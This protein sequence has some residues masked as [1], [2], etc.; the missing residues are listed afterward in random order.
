MSMPN[1]RFSRWAQLIATANPSVIGRR[2]LPR[3]DG[4][5]KLID[6]L[7]EGLRLVDVHPMS[8]VR[9]DPDDR[10]RHEGRRRCD[11]G[12]RTPNWLSNTSFAAWNSGESNLPVIVAAVIAS[13]A[14]FGNI[15]TSEFASS[16]QRG[17]DSSGPTKVTER[18]PLRSPVSMYSSA[19]AAPQEWPTRCNS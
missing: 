19:M 3:L 6:R 16:I 1:T 11:R 2:D 15:A 17:V 8:R 12:V 10:P 9:N 14:S 13:R 5:K 7:I 18:T 4:C